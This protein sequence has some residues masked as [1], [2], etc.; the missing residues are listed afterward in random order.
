MRKSARTFFTV[1]GHP[2]ELRPADVPPRLRALV[3][4]PHP[5]DFDEIA[6][7]LRRLAENGNA[8]YAAV[9][10]S[11]SG[12][13]DSYAPGLDWEKKAELRDR[14]QQASLR[15]FGLPESR[16]V[17]LSLDNDAEEGQLCDTPR[18][19]EILRALIDSQSPDLLFLPHGNDTNSAH[20]ALYAMVR[21][22]V[23]ELRM[24]L[25]MPVTLLLNRDPKTIS[26]RADLYTPF[27]Q[28]AADWKAEMLRFHD[29]QHQRNLIARGR[30]LD[31]RILEGNRQFARDLSLG[32]PYAEVFEAQT[33]S[34]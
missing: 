1:T 18:N 24:P 34:A 30:G 3:L 6:V 12:V 11:G 2:R 31:E 28:A 17:F 16:M 10:R 19:R 21:A 29:T 7:T 4:G 27:D 8:L 22:S 13:L 14:E 20:R 9:V 15:F 25:R 23:A 26:L 32:A 5:D 33:Y